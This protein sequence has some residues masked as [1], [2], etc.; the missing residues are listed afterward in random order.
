MVTECLTNCSQDAVTFGDV[1]VNFT[2]EEWTLLDLSQR[3]L[4]R[5]VMLENYKNLITT[6]Y[7]S[8]KPALISWLEQ[9]EFRTVE[10]EALQGDTY[11][12]NHCGKSFLTVQKKPSTGEKHPVFVQCGK[13]ISVTPNIVYGKTSTSEKAFKAVMVEF[14]SPAPYGRGRKR[15]WR[16]WSAAVFPVA[17]R[18]VEQVTLVSRRVVRPVHGEGDMKERLWDVRSVLKGKFGPSPTSAGTCAA[19]FSLCG[20]CDLNPRGKE[21]PLFQSALLRLPRLQLSRP[22]DHAMFR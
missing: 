8:F 13:A 4:Y 2:Q 1:A 20:L 10:R 18:P 14:P 15:K 12:D 22:D 9:G 6:G 16:H 17:L 19:A 11:E 5:D 3:N 7:K 21:F